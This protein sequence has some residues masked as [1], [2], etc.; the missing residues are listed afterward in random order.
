M[1]LKELKKMIKEEYTNYVD[2]KAI[3]EQNLPSIAV[4]DADVDAED[5]DA[6]G[7]L[8][9]IFDMLKDYFE[10]E[11]ESEDEDTSDAA[12]VMDTPPADEEEEEEE[13]LE[14][15][16]NHLQ[17]RLQKLANIIK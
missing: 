6:E 17:E 14:E 5:M 1:N 16:K 9:D 3:G 4:S 11:K 8:K 2:L 12:D 10:G 7:T 13:D 15:N